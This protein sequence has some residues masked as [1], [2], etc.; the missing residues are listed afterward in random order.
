[1][2]TAVNNSSIATIQQLTTAQESG[3][4]WCSTGWIMDDTIGRYPINTSIKTGCATAAGIQQFTPA[5]SK[6][7]VNCYGTKPSSGTNLTYSG[8]KLNL[9]PFNA[10]KYSNY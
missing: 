5:L 6:A 2:C 9:L 4:D 1:M 10:S 7:G 8:T 3:A